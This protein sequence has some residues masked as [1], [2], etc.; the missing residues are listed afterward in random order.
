MSREHKKPKFHSIITGQGLLEYI[1]EGENAQLSVEFE[2]WETPGFGNIDHVYHGGF[3]LE[4][5]RYGFTEFRY[6]P[7][8]DED[9]TIGLIEYCG[10][11]DMVPETEINNVIDTIT[12]ILNDC[13]DL[14]TQRKEARRRYFNNKAYDAEIQLHQMIKDLAAKQKELE[15]AEREYLLEE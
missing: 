1:F 15:D 7:V 11:D 12:N 2:R 4:R 5:K 6:L 9:G 8:R 13:P 10:N 14:D 3:T